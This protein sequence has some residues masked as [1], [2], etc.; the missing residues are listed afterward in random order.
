M[1]MDDDADEVRPIQKFATGAFS[2]TC[3]IVGASLA[4][5]TLSNPNS[6]HSARNRFDVAEAAKVLQDMRRDTDSAEELMSR[7]RKLTEDWPTHQS[8]GLSP[9][10]LFDMMVDKYGAPAR[11]HRQSYRHGRLGRRLS[12]DNTLSAANTEPIRFSLNFD[13]LYEDKVQQNPI[14]RDRYCFRTG[15]WYRIG[16]PKEPKPTGLSNDDCQRDALGLSIIHENKWCLCLANDV[17]T[18]EV[19]KVVMEATARAISDV[20]KYFNVRPVQGALVFKT[21]EGS[22]PGMWAQTNQQ[23]RY[24]D[25][26]CVKGSHVA[27]P[28]ALCDT[29]VPADVVLSVVMP[30]PIPDVGGTGGSCS[31]DQNGR[32]VHIVFNWHKRPD[33][34]SGKSLEALISDSRALVLHEVLHGLGFGTG[35]WGNAFTNDGKRRQIIEQRKVVDADGSEDV[36]YHFVKGTRTYDVAKHYFGCEDEDQWQGLPLMGWPPSGRDSH[37]DTRIMRDD[38]MSYGDGSAVSAITLA[39]LEDTGH[40]VANYSNADCINWGHGRGCAFVTSRCEQRPSSQIVTGLAVTSQ[41][42]R[43]WSTEYTPHNAQALRKCAQACTGTS[44]IVNGKSTCDL[45]CSTGAASS[46]SCKMQPSGD[47]PSAG[48]EGWVHDLM[49]KSLSLD[50][51]FEQSLTSDGCV[52]SLVTL[53]WLILVPLSACCWGICCKSF[54]CPSGNQAWSL[55]IFYVLTSLV[56]IG[57]LVA[58]GM[59]IYAL[60]NNALFEAYLSTSTICGVIA[61][62]MITAC[63]A[64]LSI[65]AVA[66]RKRCMMLVY[67]AG[68]SLFLA[69]FMGSVAVAAKYAEDIDSLSRSS[70]AQAGAAEDSEGAWGARNGFERDVYA[71]MESFTCRTYQSCCEPSDLFDIKAANGAPRQCKSQHEGALED[72]AF[73]LSDPSHASF[74]SMISGV[75]ASLGSAVGV[76]HLLELAAGEGFKLAHCRQEY[77]S[78]GLEGYENFISV[79]VNIY[80]A[81]MRTAGLTAACIVILMI[82]Q[83]SNLFYIY[84]QDRTAERAVQPIMLVVQPVTTDK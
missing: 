2:W 33:L 78:A 27:V 68:G 31:S 17:I 21:S 28:D 16:Y 49:Q 75:D 4:A 19:R 69:I 47:V 45:E 79:M 41:C 1:Y 70:L 83:L 35:L 58:T 36:V 50:T 81:N 43:V 22:Y 5:W 73:V 46:S 6:R 38:I 65:Y 82:V 57:G 76:C 25:A 32:P 42:A 63:F 14:L 10:P 20:P 12:G 26:D 40:Y 71:H 55:K 60:Y 37:H 18:D 15:D 77:C 39:S 74:C 3:F 67:L 34:S 7:N 72:A 44:Q 29:G 53:S 9:K 66:K 84:R 24:C 61:V 13:T 51:C 54:L 59:G 11:Q 23:G 52:Q 56:V 80:R 64:T 30:P 8:R 48:Q 62:G